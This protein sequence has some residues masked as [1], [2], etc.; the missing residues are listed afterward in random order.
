M[1]A[2][3]FLLGAC[4]YGQ[5]EMLETLEVKGDAEEPAAEE[6]SEAKKEE[7]KAEPK[8]PKEPT[9]D[10]LADKELKKLRQQRDLLAMRS[11]LRAEEVKLELAS[12][13]EEKERLTLETSLVIDR[14][15]A[16]V[17]QQRS[18]IDRI[19]VKV[20]T[21]NNQISLAN[22]EM[23]LEMQT[24]L[25]DLKRA[26]ERFDAASALAQK[27]FGVEQ[28]KLRLAEARIKV[29]RME[30]EAEFAELQAKISI[31]EK[32]DEVRDQ[33]FVRSDDA[34][35]L[36]PII[37]GVL[38]ISD[39]RVALNGL[40]WDG[41]AKH[42]SERINYFN[43]QSPEH[44]IFI[45]IDSSP[46]GSVWSGY[47]ILKE[48]E[49]SK[50]PVYVVVKSYA[51]SMAAIITAMAERSYAYPNA[52][53]LHH[54][55]GW[56]GIAGNLSKQKE[57]ADGAKEWWRRIAGPVAAKM[58]LT[59]E[60]FRTL[61]YERSSMGDWQEFAD[62]A[63]SYKWVDTVVSRM[64]ETGVE[65]NP[66]RYGEQI[67]SMA[68]AEVLRDEAGKSYVELPRLEPYDFYFIY[69]PEGYYR[70]RR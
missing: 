21:L 38:H 4:V 27:E 6:P 34:Y 25:A 56:Y 46:G 62:V 15:R 8:E 11:S 39:R 64:R 10:E 22:A 49:G 67:W 16:E 1:W 2:A 20:D 30:L 5:D 69:D 52:L 65:R 3:F 57:Y 35:P 32:A 45:V 28:E 29:R 9:A 33:V 44:P 31:K 59:L 7:A 58:G 36:D 19:A 68:T 47:R 61:M 23:R 70:M 17:A 66:D 53:I 12:M 26:G 48:M 18:E 42:V 63:Q 51:A 41:V 40:I 43:N 37:D 55:L 54:E 14:V 24:E 13:R 50:A 60:E